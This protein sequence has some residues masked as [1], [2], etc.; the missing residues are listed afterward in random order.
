MFKIELSGSGDEL[1][2]EMLKLLGLKE[3]K[4]ETESSVEEKKSPAAAVQLEPSKVRRI[5]RVRK[6]ATPHQLP[7]TEKEAKEF[8]SQIKPNARRIITE[9][10]KKPD[11]YRKNELIQVLGLKETAMRG[12]LS[13]VGNAVRKMKKE[14]SPI[15]R[16]RVD[17]ELIYR[18]DSVVAGAVSYTHLTLPT[19]RE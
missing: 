12:Q 9:L 10:A 16:E 7:W 8:L 5:R 18:L 3:P 17:G 4:V 11:G 14:N 13:S 15:K 1:R 2:I 19:N 6:S